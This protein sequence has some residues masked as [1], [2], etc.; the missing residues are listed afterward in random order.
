MSRLFLT[1]M[2]TTLLLAGCGGGETNVQNPFYAEWDTPYGVPPFAQIDVTHYEPAFTEAMARQNE[3]IAAI[4]GSDQPASFAN[5][6]EALD[7]SG[8]LLRKVSSVFFAM[9]GSMT[10]EN[11][12]AVAK[13]MAPRLSAHRDGIRLNDDLY[14]RV[15]AV[16]AQKDDLELTG[17]QAK[18]LEETNK[19]FVRG[20]ANLDAAGKEQLKKLNEELASLTVQFGEN[21][22]K[23]TNKFV[24]FIDNEAD[25]AGLPEGV[26]TA[27]AEAAA[28][29]DKPGQ[30]AFTIQKPSLIPFLQY[31]QKR[32]LREK[33]FKAYINMGDNGG[34][35]DNNA[36]LKRIANLRVEKA[37]LLG[38]DSHAAYMLSDNMAQEPG[39][40]YSLLGKLWEPA[41]ATAKGEAE[42]MQAMIDAEMGSEAFKLEAWDWWHYA[43]KVKK[44]KYDLDE[45]M[46]RPYFKLEN[47]RDGMFAVAGKLWGLEFVERPDIATYHPDVKAFLVKDRDGSELAVLMLD[48]FPRESKRGGAWM[49]SFRKQYY[50]DGERVLPLVFN[51]GNFTRPT[52]DTPSLLSVD[53]VETMFHE[54]GHGLHGMLSDCN[55]QTL[56]GTAVAQDFVELPSQIME[57]WAME[58]EVL[59][60]YAKHYQTGEVIPAE[61]VEKVKKSQH[62]NTGFATTEYLAACFLDMDW[63]T[64]TDFVEMDPH[65]FEDKSLGRINLMDEIVVRYRSPYFRHIFAGGYSAGYYSYVWAEVLDADAFQAFKET[66]DLFDQKTAAAFRENVLERGGS[67][68]PMELYKKFRGSEPGIEPLLERKG[69]GQP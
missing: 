59:A 33:M 56:S 3:E 69:M 68:E 6:I 35:L 49:S 4:T 11:M 65:Q 29:R 53:E 17:E 41:L 34:E 16:Y 62:F 14:Q 43:E 48:Y 55:Y 28:K 47:V 30:W 18:L 27:A 50:R 15:A 42:A 61:L 40:V 23:E 21:V 58:P 45:G 57:N 36:N 39:A 44:A 63:H 60:M 52:G 37:H 46:L 20:G 54:F 51:V 67:E 10:N 2:M 5:T 9:N 13:T 7:A 1:F 19:V 24:M 12:Q 38:Y 26:V 22:L 31:S 25:L 8:G 66:G 32:D 64:V